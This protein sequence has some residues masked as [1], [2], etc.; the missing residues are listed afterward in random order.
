MMMNKEEKTELFFQ[1]YPDSFEYI[2]YD[3]FGKLIYQKFK[4]SGGIYEYKYDKIGILI[5]ERIYTKAYYN[6]V[7]FM[8]IIVHK[9]CL[10]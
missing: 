7:K 5:F 6:G 2:E 10:S 4:Y 9:I 8:N 1:K 3:N